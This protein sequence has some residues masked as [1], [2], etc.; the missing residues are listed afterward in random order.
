MTRRT[1][2]VFSFIFVG[3][4]AKRDQNVGTG[5]DNYYRGNV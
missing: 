1:F 4:C 5:I 3:G 2:N